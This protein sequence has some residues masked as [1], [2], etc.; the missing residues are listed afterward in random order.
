MSK[1]RTGSTQVVRGCR[2][3]WYTHLDFDVCNL[4]TVNLLFAVPCHS[5]VY[6]KTKF[7]NDLIRRYEMKLQFYRNTTKR[8]ISFIRSIDMLL[9]TVKTKIL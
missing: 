5:C 9:T 4:P 8:E 3:D 6:S 1:R 7:L 2:S